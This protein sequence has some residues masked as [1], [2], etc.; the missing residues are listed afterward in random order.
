LAG[1]LNLYGFAGGDP[2]NFSD[3]FG[4]RGDS[5]TV[6]GL[7]SRLQVDWLLE[8][9]PTF[10]S[11]FN[12]LHDDPAVHLTIRDPVGAEWELYG[13]QFTPGEKGRG[14]ILFNLRDMVQKNM[15]LLAVGSDWLHSGPST[16]GHEL[17]HAAA[18]YGKLDAACANDPPRGGTGCIIGFENTIRAETGEHGGKRTEYE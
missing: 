6:R 12:A 1:G 9:S 4:L 16:M 8:N 17:G 2:V 18:H 5:V 11:T 10:R 7:Y 15:D 13:S 14:L 3:P